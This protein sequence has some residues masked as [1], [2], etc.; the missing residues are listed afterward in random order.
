M[1][2]K[3]HHCLMTWTKNGLGFRGKGGAAS[4]SVLPRCQVVL[5]CLLR[6][7]YT[8]R[9]QRHH[10]QQHHHRHHH[11]HHRHRHGPPDH[12]QHNH[13]HHQNHHHQVTSRHLPAVVCF[14]PKSYK[15]HHKIWRF[16]NVRFCYE[17]QSSRGANGGCFQQWRVG[18]QCRQLLKVGVWDCW[19]CWVGPW[20]ICFRVE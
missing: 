13:H 12:H 18:E 1:Q 5:D 8:Y 20:Q 7:M 14:Q 6:Y 17:L 11:H 4:L 2:G 9:Q 3:R 16:A 15:T 10:H 19:G